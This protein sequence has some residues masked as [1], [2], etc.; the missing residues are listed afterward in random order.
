MVHYPIPE[1][2][3]V[4]IKPR[5]PTTMARL[6]YFEMMAKL[7]NN[8]KMIKMP[9]RE[10]HCEYLSMGGGWRSP[11][12]RLAPGC[13]PSA[14]AVPPPHSQSPETHFP[15]PPQLDPQALSP[16]TPR[17]ALSP[18]PRLGE[19]WAKCSPEHLPP[20]HGQKSPGPDRA[21]HSQATPPQNQS[22]PA[23]KALV[24]SLLEEEPELLICPMQVPGWLG[25]QY[26][27]CSFTVFT[28]N[29]PEVQRD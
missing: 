5:V 14:C 13:T 24:F 3:F 10:E 16:A 21:P 20:P 4:A 7:G 9:P 15:P 11:S 19:P 6:L 12:G 17:G 26:V 27:L 29:L 2:M 8:L 1:N 28:N 18:P 22:R 25:R 23:G